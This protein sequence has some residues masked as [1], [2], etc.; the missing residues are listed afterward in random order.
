MVKLDISIILDSDKVNFLQIPIAYVMFGINFLQIIESMIS[1][2]NMS[3]FLVVIMTLSLGAVFSAALDGLSPVHGGSSGSGL[4]NYWTHGP[5]L[6]KRDQRYCG[7]RLFDAIRN[8]CKGNYAA[9]SRRSDPGFSGMHKCTPIV[10][11]IKITLTQSYKSKVKTQPTISACK[12][13]LCFSKARYL[14]DVSVV[15]AFF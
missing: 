6:N 3:T 10:T 5:G 14:T 9:P 7:M 15:K 1:A 8:L 11:T 2:K 12:T 4:S 13:H